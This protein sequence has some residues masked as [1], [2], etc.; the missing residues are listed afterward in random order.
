MKRKGGERGSKDGVDED[1]D[2]NGDE[3][4]DDGEEEDDAGDIHAKESRNEKA[5]MKPRL[6]YEGE[7]H[8]SGK[9]LLIRKV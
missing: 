5:K 1:V 3:D 8:E 9:N 2:D 7:N 4:D 6:I